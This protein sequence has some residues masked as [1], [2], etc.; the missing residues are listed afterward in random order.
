MSHYPQDETMNDNG[1]ECPNCG[2]MFSTEEGQFY[3]SG[4]EEYFENEECPECEMK[5][6]ISVST[7][8]TWT[9][10]HPQMCVVK[11]YHVPYI[12]K[13]YKKHECLYCQQKLRC[14]CELHDRCKH[15]LITEGEKK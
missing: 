5:L 3:P 13:E 4:S 2:F 15:Q 10:E 7:T 6:N 8:Y 14:K 1:P 9:I 11:G 12:N